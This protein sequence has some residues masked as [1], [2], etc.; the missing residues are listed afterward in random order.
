MNIGITW[1]QKNAKSEWLWYAYIISI[2]DV[3]GVFESM[4]NNNDRDAVIQYLHS[5]IND[6]CDKPV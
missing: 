2:E 6:K 5:C 3:V 4:E 1:M